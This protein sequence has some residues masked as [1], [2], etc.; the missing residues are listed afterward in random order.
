MRQF[1]GRMAIRRKGWYI[2]K[3]MGWWWSKD[4]MLWLLIEH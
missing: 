1:V 4:R 3:F 2:K